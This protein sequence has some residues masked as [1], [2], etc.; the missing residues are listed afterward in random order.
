MPKAG[1]K[2]DLYSFPLC[3]HS[4]RQGGGEGGMCEKGNVVLNMPAGQIERAG[5][6]FLRKETMSVMS[7]VRSARDPMLSCWNRV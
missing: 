1:E 7:R 3:P 5:Q 6:L 2:N 4:G